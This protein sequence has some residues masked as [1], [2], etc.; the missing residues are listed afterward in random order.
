[1]DVKTIAVIGAGA[2]GRSIAREATCAGYKTILEDVSE[3]RLDEGVTW[4]KHALDGDVTRGEVEARAVDAAL[5]NLATAGTVEEAI[6][7]ADL[8][9]ETAADEMEVKIELFT[10]LDKFAKPKA[11]FASTSASLSITEMAGVTFCAERCIGMRFLPADAKTKRIE[12]VQGLKTSDETVAMCREVAHRLG[13]E[14]VVL[15][16]FDGSAGGMPLEKS[17]SAHD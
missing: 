3:A 15:H 7:E 13:K 17:A 5:A 9:I 14:A 8:I 2:M 10:I 1:M 4:I 11:I 6:R 12:L 16:E